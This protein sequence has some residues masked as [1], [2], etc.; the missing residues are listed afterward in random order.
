MTVKHAKKHWTQ[1]KN[2]VNGNGL[3]S[4]ETDSEWDQM[5]GLTKTSKQLIK[6]KTI[7]TELKETVVKGKYDYVNATNGKS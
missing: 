7:F 6:K 2:V 1:G 3:W 5:L 4:T